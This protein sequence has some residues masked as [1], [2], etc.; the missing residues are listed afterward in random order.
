M[1]PRDEGIRKPERA[2]RTLAG[3]DPTWPAP[4]DRALD[5]RIGPLD[6]MELEDRGRASDGLRAGAHDCG[7]PVL[8]AASRFRHSRMVGEIARSD[9]PTSLVG[10]VHFGITSPL[11]SKTF[12]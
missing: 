4:V 1:P 6:H 3:E 9:N 10:L 7:E 11:S 8:V 5:A 12:P 2:R